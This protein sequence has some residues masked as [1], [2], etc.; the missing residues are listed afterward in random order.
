M[1]ILARI[2]LGTDSKVIP[3]QLLQLLRAPFFGISTMSPSVQSS[4]NVFPSQMSV[5][6][7]WNS[8]AASSGS[9]LNTSALRLSCPG[10]FPFLRDLMAAMISSFPGGSMLTSRS[11]SAS[12]ISASVNCGGLFRTSLKCFVHRASCL[13]SVVSSHPYLSMIGASV[14]PLYLPLTSLVIL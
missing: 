4:S 6:S 13:A 11:V 1:M 14:P 2:L 10:D 12:C 3:C 9:A 7:G 8:S 5:K